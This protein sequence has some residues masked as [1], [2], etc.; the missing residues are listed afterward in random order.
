MMLIDLQRFD[1]QFNNGTKSN[2]CLQADILGDW[3]EEVLTRN[4]E[5]TELRLYVSTIPTAYRINCL[6]QDIPYRLSVAT[7]NVAYNQ[8]PEP[9]YYIGPDCTDYLK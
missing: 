9:G 7:Q 3:R 1:G 5:S 6:M 4:R 8:P 2:P